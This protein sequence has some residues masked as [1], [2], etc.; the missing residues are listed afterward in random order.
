MMC[1]MK[2]RFIIMIQT[3]EMETAPERF[4]LSLLEMLPIIN[5]VKPRD[6]APL[7]TQGVPCVIAMDEE[8]FKSEAYQRVYQYLRRYQQNQNL[9]NFSYMIGC[10]EG[11][12]E[13][14]LQ[15]LLR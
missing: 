5:C 1:W 10:T 9:D 11:S 7:I 6:A 3:A 12:I 14:C 15:V 13:D 2:M 8:E 4:T